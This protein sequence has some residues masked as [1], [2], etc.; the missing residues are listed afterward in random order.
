M[1]TNPRPLKYTMR[2]IAVV[3]VA[4]SLVPEAIAYCVRDGRN[5]EWFGSSPFCGSTSSPIGGTDSDGRTLVTWTKEKDIGS[6]CGSGPSENPGPDC[7]GDYGKGCLSG[8]K[9][10]WCYQLALHSKASVEILPDLEAEALQ[11]GGGT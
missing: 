1:S 5:C 7:C 10:L 3:A 11:H 2:F 8:Y 6:L 4:A 9:R